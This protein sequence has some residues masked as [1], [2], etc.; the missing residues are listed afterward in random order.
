MQLTTQQHDTLVWQDT[1]GILQVAMYNTDTN[2]EVV[3]QCSTGD[4]SA[5]AQAH[6]Y[7]H[8]KGGTTHNLG[9][10]RA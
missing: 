2:K 8:R 7:A 5:H 3:T 1:A 6:A 9:L 10:E 4:E